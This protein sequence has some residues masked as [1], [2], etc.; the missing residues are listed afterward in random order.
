MQVIRDEL[1]KIKEEFGD[2]RRT[3]ILSDH[4]DFPWKI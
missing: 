3:E 1:M 4:E 2:K